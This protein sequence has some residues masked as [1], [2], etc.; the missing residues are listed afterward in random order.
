MIFVLLL[1][2]IYLFDNE[3]WKLNSIYISYIAKNKDI[4]S[5][6]YELWYFFNDFYNKYK[7]EL[8]KNEWWYAHQFITILQNKSFIEKLIENPFTIKTIISTYYKDKREQ[9]SYEEQQ[10]LWKIILSSFANDN[11]YLVHELNWDFNINFRNQNWIILKSIIENLNFLRKLNILWEFNTF[12][13]SNNTIFAKNCL[14]FTNKV[15][16]EFLNKEK[17]SENYKYYKLL[18][19]LFETQA[20]IIEQCFD[21]LDFSLK[22]DLLWNNFDYNI[23]NISEDLLK[24]YWWKKFPDIIFD[25]KQRYWW[26]YHELYSNKNLIDSFAFWLYR[27]SQAFAIHK[28]K[29][30]RDFTIDF[31]TSIWNNSLLF[32]EIEKR[33]LILCHQKIERNLTWEYPMISRVFWENYSREI[34]NQTKEINKKSEVIDILKLYALKLPKLL[35]W[36]IYSYTDETLEN[37]YRKEKAIWKAQTILEDLFPKYITYNKEKNTLNIFWWDNLYYSELNLSKTLE[38]WK[39]EIIKSN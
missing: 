25:E 33:F 17:I 32:N 26:K 5:L 1:K 27:L 36:Y 16:D 11:S 13:Y 30:I 29:E 20:R 12:L 23:S 7:K 31:T 21:N 8:K 4:D 19:K 3:K 18:Y 9:L 28:D 38:T 22:K 39:I 34:L 24:L 6:V 35:E 14:I 37:N 2:K 10:F 15:V